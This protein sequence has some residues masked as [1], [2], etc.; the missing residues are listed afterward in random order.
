MSGKS[1]EIQVS[2]AVLKWA[3]EAA[4]WTVKETAKKVGVGVET[5]Q[6]WESGE[7][8][9]S[10]PTLEKLATYFKRPLAAFFLPKPPPE[11]PLPT[12]FR[13][14]PGKARS[15]SKMTRL[16][17]RRARR[18]QAIAAELMEG[19][20]LEAK[21]KIGKANLTDRP[22]EVAREER[23]RLKVGIQEQLD[24]ANP[25][26]ALEAWR[27][28]VESL[29]ILVL[30]I[31][32]PV[33]DVRGFSIGDKKPPAIIVSSSD[34]IHARIFTLFHEL[35]HLVLRKPG[36]CT[37]EDALIHSGNGGG[38]ERWCNHFAGALLVPEELLQSDR[39]VK[40]IAR[41][42]GISSELL[43]KVSQR[44]KVSR[45]AIL[46]RMLSSQLI[47][48]KRYQEEIANLQLERR[49]VKQAGFALPPP[50]RCLQEK[51]R[52][53]VSL[54]VESNQKELIT[55]SEVA[56]YLSIRLKHLQKVQALIET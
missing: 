38:V 24:W 23:K 18:Q 41:S 25:Y 16:A 46:I 43:S 1:L 3:R 12:D 8:P 20:G 32:M 13:V 10:L 40:A 22:E 17:I 34:A 44:L 37:P 29:N 4:G 48:K 42:G 7:A 6:K 39:D 15:F 47:S 33:E 19:L 54:V 26:R 51:G 55:Y 50:R 52:R 30:Q 28:R 56:D 49:A 45:H 5:I 53:F 11:P 2:P 9:V 31:P 14:L 21:A 36:I 27:N 35:A